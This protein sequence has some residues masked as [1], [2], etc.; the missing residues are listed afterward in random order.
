MNIEIKIDKTW[1]INSFYDNIFG[2]NYIKKWGH[3]RKAIFRWYPQLWEKLNNITDTEERKKII[4]EYIDGLYIKYD[5]KLQTIV[6]KLKSL[7]EN[8]KEKIIAGL[9][10][11]MD[12]NP[13]EIPQVTIIPSFKPNST[14]WTDRINLS[15][16]LEV[17]KD[18]TNPYID[19]FVHEIT[20][21]IWNQKI[22]KI[23]DIVW[24]L[25]PLAHE[26][27]KEIV[28]PVIMRDSHFRDIL[29]SE[30]MKNA[31]EKQQL[32]QINVNWTKHNIVDYFESI[33]QDMKGKWD[34]FEE[35]MKE[36]VKIFLKI[37]DQIIAK[38]RIYNEFW[39]VSKDKE[40]AL[41]ILKEKWY[42]DP[43]ILG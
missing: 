16:A 39:F 11:T 30:Y 27:L 21:I 5:T 41:K 25:W 19:I 9:V 37:E 2:E 29:Q 20:H 8:N 10:T 18:K 15:I 13:Q 35:I 3:V 31:N 28:T 38:H 14:F 23:Y 1:D 32:L 33:Y 4:Y 22:W 42:M 40:E 43:I 34:S 6:Q 7:F 26:D 17:F 12:F 24:K 36:F